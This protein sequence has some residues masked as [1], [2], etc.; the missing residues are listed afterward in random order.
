[1]KHKATKSEHIVELAPGEPMRFGKL[2]EKGIMLDGKLEPKVVSVDEVGEEA[3]LVYD[4]TSEICAA[5]VSRLGP[6]NFP[7]PIGVF[8]AVQ[9]PTYEAMLVDQID[10]A[11]AAKTQRVQD[12]LDV[13]VWT[14]K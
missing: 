9:K 14:V 12:L 13:G 11:S 7:T 8:R 4:E 3:L 2:G 5:V 10:R 1:M 6:P